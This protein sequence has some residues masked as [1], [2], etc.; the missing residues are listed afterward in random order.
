MAYQYQEDFLYFITYKTYHSLDFFQSDRNKEI[1]EQQILYAG[2]KYSIDI[3]AYAILSNHYHL[4]INVQDSNVSRNKFIQ[5]IN[6]GSSFRIDKSINTEHVWERANK[7]NSW[8]KD[9]NSMFRVIGYICGN[10][11]KHR[12][13]KNFKELS[14]YEYCNYNDV[15]KIYNKELVNN[16]IL[17]NCALDFETM[18]V[19]ETGKK[20]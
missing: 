20:E 1:L 4:L 13:V 18:D 2:K 10:P 7:Y 8:L 9:E 3:I 19:F 14:K 11:L 15:C 6:G 12:L 5:I 16:L 17:E